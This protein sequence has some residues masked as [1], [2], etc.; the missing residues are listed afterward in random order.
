MGEK[1]RGICK[2]PGH[3]DSV[4][5]HRGI[6]ERVY[7]NFFSLFS[8]FVVSILLHISRVIFIMSFFF[9]RGE[10]NLDPIWL[11]MAVELYYKCPLE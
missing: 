4:S 3:D 7:H 9:E 8:A 11:R 6:N 10:L 1:K 5:L 2:R